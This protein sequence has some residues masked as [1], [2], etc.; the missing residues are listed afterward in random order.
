MLANS[1]NHSSPL[2]I[3]ANDHSSN[4]R[5]CIARAADAPGRVPLIGT[6]VGAGRI[7]ISFMIGTSALIGFAFASKGSDLSKRCISLLAES[8]HEIIR[9][10]QEL[11]PF[12]SIIAD[13]LKKNPEMEKLQKIVLDYNQN[14]QEYLQNNSD[15]KVLSEGN[16]FVFKLKDKPNLV[17]KVESRD[18]ANWHDALQN[19]QGR[20]NVT[21][22]A[23]LI[24]NQHNLDRLIVPRI[25]KI[26][27]GKQTVL[28]EEFIPD[29]N[30]PLSVL[31]NRYR[32]AGPEIARQLATFICLTGFCDVKY[33]NI[34]IDLN[35]KVALIDLETTGHPSAAIYGAGGNIPH[36]LG[37]I[38]CLQ[39]RE[40]IMAAIHA[41]YARDYLNEMTK[42]TV[43]YRLEIIDIQTTA[44]ASYFNRRIT[45]ENPAQPIDNNEAIGKLEERIDLNEEISVLDQKYNNVNTTVKEMLMA[46]INLLNLL[47]ENNEK[48]SNSPIWMTRS[49]DLT[50]GY[51]KD[52]SKKALF[53]FK[54]KYKN[55]GVPTF[56]N[57]EMDTK[58]YGSE[59]ECYAKT[60]KLHAI[61]SA[62]KDAGY[63]IDFPKNLL[64]AF[65][66]PYL[67]IQL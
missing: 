19:W 63:I 8:K 42:K 48:V 10:F 59:D 38:N 2:L 35:G 18:H 67:R 61:F 33:D 17:F 26:L 1:Y 44:E 37:L 23:Q 28:I 53:F 58:G 32:E 24:C 65:R 30:V 25:D 41:P 39:S 54:E 11:I 14:N 57:G 51:K 12:V 27:I 45:K 56:D 4:N 36:H 3:Q 62:L 21:K 47:M 40:Q 46:T 5:S 31:Q 29:I 52:P 50:G 16:N 34:P 66:S 22:N 6:A 7:I 15:L 49:I 13:K 9:G 55:A 43:D 20:Y 64:G 60:S